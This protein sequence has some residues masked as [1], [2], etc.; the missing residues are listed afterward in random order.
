MHLII[1]IIETPLPLLLRE[2]NIMTTLKGTRLLDTSN[3]VINPSII[4]V[5]TKIIEVKIREVETRHREM[6]KGHNL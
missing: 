4:K 3:M 1:Q 2:A 5:R 6:D